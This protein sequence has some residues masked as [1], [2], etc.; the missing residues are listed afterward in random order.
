MPF[1]ISVSRPLLPTF[2][3]MSVYARRVDDARFYSNGGPMSELLR[4]RLASHLRLDGSQIALANSGTSAI[5]A[6]L[7]ATVGR[8]RESRTRCICPAFTFAATPAAAQ[9]AGYEPWFV[10]I[11]PTTWVLDSGKVEQLPCLKRAAAVIVVAPHGRTVDLRAWENFAARTG[12]KVVVDAAAGFDTLDSSAIRGTSIPVAVSLHATKTLSSAEGGLMLCGAPDVVSRASAAVNFGFTDSRISELPG[13]NG[14]MSEFHAIVGLADLDNWREK[15]AGFKRSAAVY[16]SC[17]EVAGIAERVLVDTKN[18]VPYV[19][20]LC[21]NE[22]EV[23]RVIK[24]L[25]QARIEWRHWYSGSLETHP[26]FAACLAENTPVARDVSTRAIGLP[27]SVDLGAE[28][29][30]EIVSV[31]AEAVTRPLVSV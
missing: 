4:S 3:Q 26:A 7:L 9:A 6:L 8:P 5:T 18:A 31:V 29:I 23:R 25:D 27:F 20:Y 11:D 2:E 24:A 14:K 16:A 28:Q 22:D 12:L 13:F 21:K 30:S 19:H 15:R 17:S 1:K 10:D